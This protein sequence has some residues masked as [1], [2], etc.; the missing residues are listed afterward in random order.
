VIRR[1]MPPGQRTV[2]SWAPSERCLVE[3]SRSSSPN[4]RKVAR[5]M[6]ISPARSHGGPGDGWR[7]TRCVGAHV[8]RSRTAVPRCAS[9]ALHQRH[10]LRS[11][12]PVVAG[13]RPMR[14]TAGWARDTEW[15]GGPRCH[16][17]SARPSVGARFTE[18][19]MT[20]PYR[21]GRARGCGLA[22]LDLPMRRVPEEGSR[23]C[24]RHHRGSMASRSTGARACCRRRGSVDDDVGPEDHATR[25]CDPARR[26]WSVPWGLHKS[27]GAS[28]GD[29]DARSL[30]SL[31]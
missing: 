13:V 27:T 24:S 20:G 15:C 8:R 11:G 6:P 10:T 14:K 2:R 19:I 31:W 30:P 25:Y 7:F 29:T 18:H 9:S 16:P 23:W 22:D 4:R 5:P 3:N 21:D 17:V 28:G 12:P 26:V 1:T